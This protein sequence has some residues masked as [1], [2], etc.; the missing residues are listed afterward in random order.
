MIKIK[1]IPGRTPHRVWYSRTDV[2]V[3]EVLIEHSSLALLE[4]VHVYVLEHRNTTTNSGEGVGYHGKT[5]NDKKN[6]GGG[7]GELQLK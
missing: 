2:R 6:T 1:I 4:Y 7:V 5:I 3:L